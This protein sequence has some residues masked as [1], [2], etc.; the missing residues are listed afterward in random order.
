M[1]QIVDSPFSGG[2]LQSCRPGQ[3]S[4]SS[5]HFQAGVHEGLD[6][7]GEGFFRTF[8]LWGTRCRGRRPGGCGHA[9]HVSSWTP[10]AY[11]DLEAADEPA[12]LEEGVELLI[13]EEEDPSGWYVSWN[14]QKKNVVL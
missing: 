7:P 3:I 1:E 8:P 14:V 4:S 9:P 12:E 5:S 10:A 13:E 6:E 11:E 2:G